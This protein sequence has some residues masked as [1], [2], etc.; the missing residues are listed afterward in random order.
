MY[1][2]EGRCECTGRRGGVCIGRRGGVSIQG[3]GEVCV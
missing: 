3:G 2:E 1:R